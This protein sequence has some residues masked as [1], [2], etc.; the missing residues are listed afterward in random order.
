M[1]MRMIDVDDFIKEYCEGCAYKCP[2]HYPKCDEMI[3]LESYAEE[4]A[5]ECLTQPEHPEEGEQ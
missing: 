4:N 5:I 3:H 1:K 2:L